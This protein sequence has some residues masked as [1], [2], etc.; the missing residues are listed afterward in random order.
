MYNYIYMCFDNSTK[1]SSLHSVDANS[2][3]AF[4]TTKTFFSRSI[5]CVSWW[6]LG[7]VLDSHTY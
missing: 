6:S 7:R 5:M 3:V 2:S 4:S 1:Q